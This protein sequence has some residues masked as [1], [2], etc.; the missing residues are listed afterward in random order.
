MSTINT[1]KGYYGLYSHTGIDTPKRVSRPMRSDYRF[2][3]F[4]STDDEKRYLRVKVQTL[5]RARLSQK[6]RADHLEEENKELKKEQIKNHKDLEKAKLEI[7][8]LRR[9]RDMYKKMLFK[10]NSKKQDLPSS[11]KENNLLNLKR[12]R[13]REKGHLGISR[14]LPQK[15]PDK[16]KRVFFTHC[17]DCRHKLQR[18]ESVDTHIVE[19]I[20]QP[21]SIKVVVTRYD[22]ERQWCKT[23]RKE[24]VAVSP[25]E[26]PGSKLGINLLVHIMILKYGC[27][28]SLEA[29]SLLL[30]Q[31]YSLKISKGGIIQ[32]LHRARDHLGEKYIK[33]RDAVRASPVKHADETGWRIN[34]QN[35]WMW[36]FLTKQ[37]VYLTIEETRGGGI[38]KRELEGMHEDDVLVRDDYGAY[39]NLPLKHQ[40]CWAHLRRK[41]RDSAN[42]KDASL[43]VKKLDS[44]LKN[45]FNLL[46]STVSKPF[47]KVER[48]KVYQQA[49][50]TLSSIIAASYTKQD[51]IDIQ[52]RIRN[53]GKNLLTALLY[54]NVPLTN[55]LAERSLRPLVVQRKISGGSRSWNGARTTA[56]N[57]SVYQTIQLQNLPLAQTLK[58]YLLTGAAGNS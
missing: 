37:E 30:Y 50:Q 22:K 1:P 56:V 41:S 24:V 25:G 27:K 43:E 11:K 36:D 54:D 9:Q 4:Q 45:L 57:T 29:I 32:I 16:V 2:Y 53:Q 33:I 19:D 55:N 40:S 47:E 58:E 15:E 7:E 3:R 31:T 48:A 21:Q 34:G 20:P 51:A 35:C 13:G 17:P 18:T 49:W 44:Q 28:M 52:T 12:K 5:E 42:D 38:P 14:T 46:S 8:K 26:I 39:K 10:E 6:Q 23:C